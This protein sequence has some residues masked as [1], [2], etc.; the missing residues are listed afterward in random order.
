MKRVAVF[1]FCALAALCI[2]LAATPLTQAA[3]DGRVD[4]YADGIRIG[5]D[6]TKVSLLTTG[7]ATLTSGTTSVAVTVTSAATGDIAIV[8]P[9]TTLGDAAEF[10]GSISGT[11]LTISVDA[12]PG[13]DV[14]FNYLV[15]GI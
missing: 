4:R 15:L 11:T 10:R 12:N 2:W 3:D 1:V 13:R 7:T 14:G 8:S 6:G 9:T 5:S